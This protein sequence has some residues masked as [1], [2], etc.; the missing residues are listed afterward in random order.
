M[1]QKK[2]IYSWQK[3]LLSIIVGIAVKVVVTICLTVVILGILVS[4]VPISNAQSIVST[5]VT[6]NT[7]QTT[8][9]AATVYR[10]PECNC[11]GKWIDHLKTQGFAIE[12][13]TT[14]DIEAVK[15]KYKVPDNLTSCHT[16]I[17]NGYVIEGHV[18]AEDIKRLLQ[19]KPNI[20]GLSV[21][22][23]PVGTPG[24]EIGNK[25]DP[26]TVFSFDNKSRVEV[27]NKYPSSQSKLSKTGMG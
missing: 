7:Q 14:S 4:N 15:Q 5:Y 13:L 20:T 16:A 21:P 8:V 6:A 25:K 26:Y 24:M 27:F 10:S 1:F 12:D 2:F 3:W 18:P 23:M 19:E 17:V 11:C 9:P 22:H